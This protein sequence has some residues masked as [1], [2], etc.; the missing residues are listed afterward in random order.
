MTL[1]NNNQ[2]F[3]IHS[4][5]RDIG[6]KKSELLIYAI[7][8]AFTCGDIGLFY[9]SQKHLAYLSGLSLRSV[10]RAI[11]SLLAKGYITRIKKA[12][13]KG[14]KCV[15][16]GD[17]QANFN[18]ATPCVTNTKTIKKDAESEIYKE[19]F[20]KKESSQNPPLTLSVTDA[21]KSY[22]GSSQRSVGRTVKYDVKGYGRYGFVDMTEAQY[23]SLLTLVDS[24]VLLSYVRR[25]ERMLENNTGA[26]PP[27]P[28]SAYK[29]LKKWIE[30]DYG[31]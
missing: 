16:I 27:R 4:F 1:Q 12:G 26:S 3:V 8:Y 21:F 9:G 30:A 28:H 24:E 18:K 14:I 31:V 13:Y 29:T 5:M 19:N 23:N 10:Q 25:F 7:L 20:R 6:L 2:I 17:K 11:S 15:E 22:I